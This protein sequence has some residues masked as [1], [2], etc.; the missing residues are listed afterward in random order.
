MANLHETARD[1]AA[2]G[3]VAHVVEFKKVGGR[4]RFSGVRCGENQPATIV[5]GGETYALNIMATYLP[6]HTI[7]YV[8]GH[9]D[10]MLLWQD[11]STE[12]LARQTLRDAAARAN[13]MGATGLRLERWMEGGLSITVDKRAFKKRTFLQII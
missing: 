4:K 3:Y 2:K 12:R 7:S 6:T 8:N 5:D 13:W 11:K 9:N 1:L 10:G